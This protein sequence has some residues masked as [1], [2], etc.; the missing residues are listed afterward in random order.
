MKAVL[1]PNPYRDKGLKVALGARKILEN[2][3]VDT[4]VC[5]PFDPEE[6]GR[7]EVPDGLQLGKLAQELKGADVLVCFGGDGTILHAARDATPHRVPILGINLG[8]VGFMAELEQGELSLLSRLAGGKFDVE[9]RMMLDVA[10]FFSR[11]AERID[12][13][14]FW[15]TME[16]LKYGTIAQSILWAMVR[17]CGIDATSLPGLCEACP[18]Q[19]G[20]ILD[21][22]E[23]GGWL[24]KIDEKDREEGWYEYNRQLLMK[25]R[26]KA[27]YLL[28]MLHWKIGAYLKAL[29]PSRKTLAIRYPCVQKSVIVIPFAWVHRLIFR[30]SRAVKKGALT[31]YIVTDEKKIGASAQERVQMFKNLGMMD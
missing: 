19:V 27:Q 24:G 15:K 10:L 9:R 31:T 28:F 12:S 30:G 13:A 5:L 14:R 2:S 3:G 23:N 29:F 18:K 6:G 11:H 21:D 7:A 25:N 22:L 20:M 26:S 8:S 4:A 16:S 1:C 17:Y